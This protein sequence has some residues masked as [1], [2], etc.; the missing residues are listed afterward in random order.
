[1]MADN[2]S[3]RAKATTMLTTK[4]KCISLFVLLASIS[5]GEASSSS[6][7]IQRPRPKSQSSCSTAFKSKD[8]TV[9]SGKE[10]IISDSVTFSSPSHVNTIRGGNSEERALLVR[11]KIGFYFALWYILNIVYNSEFIDLY[12]NSINLNS[13]SN[14]YNIL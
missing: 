13:L 4:L 6:R 2:K 8:V 1:M 5:R 9:C 11:L 10:P 3:N 14:L 7:S 12:K